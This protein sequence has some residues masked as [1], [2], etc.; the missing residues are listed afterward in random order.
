M[1]LI[2]KLTLILMWSLQSE[3]TI[4]NYLFKE[5]HEVQIQESWRTLGDTAIIKLPH[6]AEQ[7]KKTLAV[8]DP[9]TIK[10]GYEGVYFE[11]EFVGFV[12]KIVP[13]QPYQIE[14]E[15]ELFH[16]KRTNLKKL[17][18]EKTTLQAVVSYIVSQIN[19]QRKRQITL[20]AQAP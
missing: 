13:K 16:A 7:L 14:C 1:H 11:E 20:L 5:V 12:T 9:V 3:I 17:F 4:G 10:L 18:K 15:D 2:I 8:G 19:A 6:L